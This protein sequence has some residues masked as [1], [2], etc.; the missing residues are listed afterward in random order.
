MPEIIWQN[1]AYVD[2]QHRLAR[3]VRSGDGEVTF[4]VEHGYNAMNE[5]QW[6]R[7]EEAF[8]EFLIAAGT[9]MQA[10]KNS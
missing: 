7:H 6:K 5:Q 10:Q 1:D 3:A 8:R 4:E 2:G 9:I